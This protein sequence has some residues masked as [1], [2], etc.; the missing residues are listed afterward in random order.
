MCRQAA[1]QDD[2]PPIIFFFYFEFP[3]F[4]EIPPKFFSISMPQSSKRSECLRNLRKMLHLHVTQADFELKILCWPSSQSRSAAMLPRE[5]WMS[6]QSFDSLLSL[7]Q[8]HPVFY[9]NSNLPQQ[10]V[11]DQLMVTLR[12][13]G[14]SGNGSTIGMLARLF[15]ISEGAI[16]LFCNHV[17]VAILALERSFG[18]HQVHQC[19]SL[20]TCCDLVKTGPMFLGPTAM[21]KSPQLMLRNSRKGL[22]GLATLFVCNR[23]KQIT[24]YL[25]GWP[26]CSHNTC[27]WENCDLNLQS[28]HFFSPGQYLIADSG[29]STKTTLVPTFKKSL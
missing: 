16:I 23:N 2:L 24:Y 1:W 14:T 29:F 18:D 7:I 20:T 5:F 21:N 27:L 28:D 12:Q 10:P 15:R 22:Y 19:L 3:F 26:S 25:T 4:S 9:S 6:H 17:V 8:N 13:M 11:H